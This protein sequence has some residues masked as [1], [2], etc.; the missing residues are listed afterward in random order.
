MGAKITGF[1]GGGRVPSSKN[2]KK[3][4]ILNFNTIFAARFKIQLID[5][6]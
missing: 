6:K 2:Q 5:F 1:F 4:S 3:F